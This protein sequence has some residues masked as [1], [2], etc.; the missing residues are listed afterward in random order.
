MVPGENKIVENILADAQFNTINLDNV[1][2]KYVCSNKVLEVL[3]TIDC[4]KEISVLKAE[5][6]HSDLLPAVYE[7]DI[8]VQNKIN[9]LLSILPRWI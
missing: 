6:N 5:Q 1:R 8:Y 2:V 9:Y 7:G 4:P 3:R